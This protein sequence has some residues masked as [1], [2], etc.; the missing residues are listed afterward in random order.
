MLY[1]PILSG[2]KSKFLRLTLYEAVLFVVLVIELSDLFIPLA[3]NVLFLFSIAVF[4]FFKAYQ[5]YYK[6]H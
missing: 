3:S 2:Q 5:V 1:K 6:E 4:D